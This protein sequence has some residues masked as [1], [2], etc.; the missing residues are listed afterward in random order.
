[1]T[2]IVFINNGVS[3]QDL[4]TT[5]DIIAVHTGV[6]HRK[7]KDIIHKYRSYLEVLGVSTSYQA[8]TSIKKESLKTDLSKPPKGSKGGRPEII[9][10]LNEP[11]ATFLITLLKNTP[12]VVEFKQELV[13]QFFLMRAEL[14]KRQQARA[15]LKPIRRELTDAIKD[16]EDLS[17]NKWAYKMFTDLA[18]SVAIGKTSSQIKKD[19]GAEPKAPAVSFLTADELEALS[20]ISNQIAVLIDLGMN[21]PEI[22]TA[23]KKKHSP[24]KVRTFFTT[25]CTVCQ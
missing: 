22:K 25:K 5:S 11:Q 20:V 17:A 21:Y 12:V 16:R 1:M 19:R 6:E 14:M 2:D 23:I 18:Y 24:G 13:R 7:L 4:Y 3:K 15:D 10:R 8:E 9:Y